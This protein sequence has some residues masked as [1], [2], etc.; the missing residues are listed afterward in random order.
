LQNIHSI[1]VAIKRSAF[2]CAGVRGLDGINCQCKSV[3]NTSASAKRF[4]STH[5][6]SKENQKP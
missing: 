2:T 3:M 1:C 4:N 5:S 6:R